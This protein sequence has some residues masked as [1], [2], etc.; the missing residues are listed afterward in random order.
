MKTKLIALLLL[1]ASS[2]V[3][4]KAALTTPTDLAQ[5]GIQNLQFSADV[6]AG[7]IFV[8]ELKR[9][10]K[11]DQNYIRRLYIIPLKGQNNVKVDI[12][13][14]ESQKFFNPSEN[15]RI[16]IKTPFG[17]FHHQ[18]AGLEGQ[19]GGQKFTFRVNEW[20]NGKEITTNYAFDCFL[21]EKS[22]GPD[23]VKSI[24]HGSSFVT[25]EKY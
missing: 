24:E 5:L 19:L 1:T 4:Q 10:N 23:A 20:K 8:I 16:V 9:E 17:T 25:A 22:E 2:M 14:L 21:I 11:E 6:P 7:K 15:N 18:S 12:P 13:L 3:A